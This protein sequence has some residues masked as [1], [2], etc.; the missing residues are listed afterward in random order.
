VTA[1]ALYQ[2]WLGATLME[3]IR[4][5]RSPLDVAMATTRQLLNLPPGD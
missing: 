2:L 3:K 1:A 5:D 4:R